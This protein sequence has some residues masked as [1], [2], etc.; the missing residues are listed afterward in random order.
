M[1]ITIWRVRCKYWIKLKHLWITWFITF[2]KNLK[3]Q[4][5]IFTCWNFF[6]E[7]FCRSTFLYSGK[8]IRSTIIWQIDIWQTDHICITFTFVF[9]KKNDPLLILFINSAQIFTYNCLDCLHIN[10]IYIILELYII[11]VI[12]YIYIIYIIL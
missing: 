8:T 12:Y 11:Y 3:E 4:K 7:I 9:S 10:I 1:P 2:I 5:H 6:F